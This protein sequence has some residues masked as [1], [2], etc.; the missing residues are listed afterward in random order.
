MVQSSVGVNVGLPVGEQ[1]KGLC[2][3]PGVEWLLT[4]SGSSVVLAVIIEMSGGRYREDCAA[5]TVWLH[6]SLYDQAECL[7]NALPN[8]YRA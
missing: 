4:S 2:Y 3:I 1:W 5:V 8:H 6:C 7:N